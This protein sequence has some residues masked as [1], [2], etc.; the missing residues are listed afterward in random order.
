MVLASMAKKNLS[1]TYRFKN[2]EKMES[3]NR[4]I[5]FSIELKV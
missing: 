1:L 5:F 3:L 4:T 2:L